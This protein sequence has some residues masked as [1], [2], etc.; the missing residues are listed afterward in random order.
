MDE[1]KLA[2]LYG[3]ALTVRLPPSFRSIADLVPIP[4]NQEVWVSSEPKPEINLVFE[5]VE[6]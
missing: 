5:I 3:G 4:D 2:D 6:R 1:L